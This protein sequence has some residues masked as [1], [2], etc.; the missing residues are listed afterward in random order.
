V[1]RQR[2]QRGSEGVCKVA[3]RQHKEATRQGDEAMRH[4]F[5]VAQGEEATI[6]QETRRKGKKKKIEGKEKKKK[7]ECEER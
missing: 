4:Q 1:K 6:R 2:G 7:N 5:K 3:R